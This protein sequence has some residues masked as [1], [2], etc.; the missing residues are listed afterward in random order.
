MLGKE[1]TGF[2]FHL[3]AKT[4]VTV[5][6]GMGLFMC[7]SLTSTDFHTFPQMIST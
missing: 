2:C 7:V 6:I 1:E 3:G 4:C 5:D